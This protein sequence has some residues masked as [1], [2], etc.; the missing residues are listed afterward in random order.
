MLIKAADDQSARLSELEIAM[1]GNGPDAAHAKQAFY[2]LKA[3]IKGE[4]GSA[5]FIDFDYA[6]NPNWAVIHDLR[7]E[8]AGRVAQID[9]V[10]INRFM[11]V[12]ALETK[13]FNSGVKITEE[14]EFLRWNDWKRRY[15]PMD[16][17]L[18]QN[19]R[20]ISV[21]RDAFDTLPLPERLGLRLKPSFVSFV[22]VSNKAKIIRPDRFDTRQVIKADQLKSRIDR[23]L[24]QV[25]VLGALALTS[26]LVSAETVE[27]LARGLAGLHRPAV[28]RS[29]GQTDTVEPPR[30]LAASPVVVPAVT[31]Q[32]TLPGPRCKT[33]GKGAGSILHGQYGYY[34]K[35]T[36]C[37]ANT[38][39]RFTCQP[40]HKP[41]LRK[42][43]TVFFRDCAECG[44]SEPF[45]A[46]PEAR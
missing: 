45:H 28:H 32:P 1:Q 3:G 27:K 43:G 41:R 42:A 12:Y 36:V 21:L 38:A 29:P 11:E 33:C 16:S 4:E 14:G 10:L 23:D 46:N 8:H 20:H 18:A 17:P 39:I 35:C 26:K 37:E 40:G 30:P 5:Y 22:L 13:Y 44:S 9:H 2:T 25:N 34:F 6:R 7:L 24:D 19:E 31:P 15:E